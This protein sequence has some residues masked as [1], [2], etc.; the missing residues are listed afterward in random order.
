MAWRSLDN[1]K[2]QGIHPLPGAVFVNGFYIYIDFL[3]NYLYNITVCGLTKFLIL[4]PDRACDLEDLRQF[5]WQFCFP[6]FSQA[7][8][9]P[10]FLN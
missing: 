6:L 1:V 5:S 4:S 8:L 2:N 9:K 10:A 7:A 3:I